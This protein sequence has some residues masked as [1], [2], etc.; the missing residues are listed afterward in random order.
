MTGKAV[1]R[2]AKE[3]ARQLS[4]AGLAGLAVGGLMMAIGLVFLVL[5]WLSPSD[6]DAAQSIASESAGRMTTLLS[7]VDAAVQHESVLAAA[8]QVPE[9][10]P[11]QTEAVVQALAEQGQAERV[12]VRVYPPR[13]EEIEVGSYP[14]PDFTTVQMLIE[15]RRQGAARTRLR[16]AGTADQH[17]AFARAVVDDAEDV[18][19]I[20]L[21]RMSADALLGLLQSPERGTWIRLTQGSRVLRSQPADQADTAALGQHTVEGS[22]LTIEW[23]VPA[24]GGVLTPAQSILLLIVGLL[25]AG[26]GTLVRF[27]PLGRVLA[28]S[29]PVRPP[30]ASPTSASA[31]DKTMPPKPA[32]TA[33]PAAEPETT[34]PE[35]LSAQDESDEA[36]PDLPDWLLDEGGGLPFGDESERSTGDSDQAQP[37]DEPA[38]QSPESAPSEPSSGGLELEVPD[39]DEI[40][41]QIDDA[42]EPA[43]TP[44]SSA[45]EAPAD[46]AP[47]VGDGLDYL[48]DSTDSGEEKLEN[49]L[50]ERDPADDE[51]AAPPEHDVDSGLEWHT[52]FEAPA[53][54]S[55][56]PEAPAEEP[57]RAEESS[58]SLDSGLD[59]DFDVDQPA[60]SHDTSDE[61]SHPIDT[62]ATEAAEEPAPK[63][64]P[65]EEQLGEKL[66]EKTEEAPSEEERLLAIVAGSDLFAPSLFKNDGIRGVVD[67]TFDARRATE[68]G[69]AIGT[70]AAGAG[71]RS[72]AVGRDGR[73]SGPVLMS[74]LIRGLRNAGM[75][76]I[77]AGAVP[78]PA[79]WHAAFEMADGC[80]VM[81]G[82][83]HHGPVENGLQAMLGGRMLGREQLLQA[84]VV[85]VQEEFTEGEGGYSQENAA[86]AYA[87]AL[88]ATVELKRPL[89][90][91]V[92]CGNGIAGTI[93]PILL[94]AL[95]IDLIPLY[96]DVDGSFPNHRPDPTDPECLE[97]LRLCVRNFRADLGFAFDG[98]GDRLALVSNESEVA[99]ADQVLMLLT[100][101]LLSDD[102]EARVVLDV[103]CAG[104]LRRMIETAGGQAFLAP[105]GGVQ[106]ARHLVE[107]KAALGGTIDGQFT[108][109]RNWYPFGD[110]ICTAVRLLELL[111]ADRRSVQE[112][113]DELPESR[114]TGALPIAI[115]VEQGR[116]LVAGL[117]ASVD[118]G[119]AELTMIDGVR[120]DFSDRWGLL[121][122]N[123]DDGTVEL[124]LGGD[125]AAALNRI[126]AEFRDWLLSLDPN[127][128]MPF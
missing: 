106:V 87:T 120:I 97:D 53:Q 24:A 119:E 84:A 89:K 41:A 46:V 12:D 29:D 43:R 127:L 6:P 18:V 63:D 52:D 37:A 47:Q 59:L 28:G 14:E 101:A 76:V 68:L 102:P 35:R 113:L 45:E 99:G 92:D 42:D 100:R 50:V 79:L 57:A 30:M 117:R 11:E 74:A 51:R 95:E 122:V 19:A 110:A 111:T 81:V 9:N 4:L 55:S 124:R 73:V 38:G 21:V 23:G 54:E 48:T 15:A 126:K 112:H 22:A 72:I 96:C 2:S 93:V 118:F 34:A 32:P 114:T 82:A 83:S 3:R 8:R 94:E 31:Q 67:R 108:V 44:E 5:L 62:P 71:H 64:A 107:E 10:A 121:R 123:V 77:E 61:R 39:L 78:S 40:L 105:A 69:R 125:D 70:L 88:A 80:G 17:L 27:G 13:A 16:M 86:R 49:E 104:R 116:R 56:R 115:D 109:V 85:A 65:V 33:S 66:E 98:G 25:L 90:V 91:V 20:V 1:R 60:E 7:E 36:K 58:L 103:R 75:D 26:A 128:V